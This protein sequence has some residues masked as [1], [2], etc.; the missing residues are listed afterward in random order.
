MEDQVTVEIK[1]IQDL[2]DNQ[3]QK[4]PKE[5]LV[6]QGIQGNLVLQDLLDK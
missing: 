2:Q 5:W 6:L 3:D 1:V 4:D